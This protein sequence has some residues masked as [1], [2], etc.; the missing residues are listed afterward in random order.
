MKGIFIFTIS[1]LVGVGMMFF[2]SSNK[3]IT[4]LPTPIAKKKILCPTFSIEPPPSES[5][6][7][8]IIEKVGT[9]FWES[10][11]ATSPAKLK[12]EIKI[13]QGERLITKEKSSATVN[14]E[15][16]GLIKL[17][18]NSDLSLIQTLPIDFVVGQ[19]NGTVD[20]EITGTTPLSIRVRS[21][22]VTKT[23]GKIKVTMEKD[24]PIIMI[25]TLEGK[26]TIGFN[27]LDFISQVFTL[28]EG[29]VYE[30][31]SDEH[32]AINQKNK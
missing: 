23:S 24:D 13:Q 4:I 1:F 30:Y 14:F 31:N 15:N 20:Y 10:R 5:L 32:T 25:S 21:A 16:F 22:L 27:D 11:V 19:N 18:E 17:S 28:K 9:L 2:Y 8:I 12:D 26:A 6:K 3:F 7:G 29:Q